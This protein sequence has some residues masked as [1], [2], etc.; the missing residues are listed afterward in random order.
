MDVKQQKSAKQL[1]IRSGLHAGKGLGDRVADFT[2]FTGL[3]N[4]ADWYTDN[5]GN[6]CG[7]GARQEK[8]NDMFPDIF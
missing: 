6:D 1:H 7:C 5:T 4:L 2:R 3:D 8:L